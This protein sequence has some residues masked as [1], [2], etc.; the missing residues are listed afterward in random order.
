MKFPR[1]VERY[2]ESLNE[3]KEWTIHYL[4]HDKRRNISD[5]VTQNEQLRALLRAL[6]ERTEAEEKEQ[7]KLVY[8]ALLPL[9]PLC[10]SPLSTEVT[11]SYTLLFLLASSLFTFLCFFRASSGLQTCANGFSCSRANFK[12]WS[13]PEST[14]HNSYLSFFVFFLSFRF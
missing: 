1:K 11:H 4:I 2:F 13:S 5:L 14:S 7:A 12:T 8:V 9:A 10:H 6:S 3:K